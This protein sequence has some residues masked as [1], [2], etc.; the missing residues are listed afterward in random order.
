MLVV[1]AG[2]LDM[3]RTSG[4]LRSCGRVCTRPATHCV[5]ESRGPKG[6][7]LIR[8]AKTK[9]VKMKTLV[10]PLLVLDGAS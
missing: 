7:A 5:N 9:K 3:P 10:R 2:R 8:I 6:M 4:T 1:R